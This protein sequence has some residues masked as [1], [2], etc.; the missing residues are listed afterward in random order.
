MIHISIRDF[1]EK[2]TIHF[3]YKINKNNLIMNHINEI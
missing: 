2:E 3:V 1:N